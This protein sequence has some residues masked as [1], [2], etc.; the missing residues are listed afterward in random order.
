[1]WDSTD[2][3][4]ASGR[5]PP[6]LSESLSEA[7]DWGGAVW[8]DHRGLP[9]GESP[10]AGTLVTPSPLL[11]GAGGQL[12]AHAAAWLGMRLDESA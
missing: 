7:W 12:R 10:I 8:M 9:P 5:P 1:M 6:L 2:V 3:H 11:D 4:S